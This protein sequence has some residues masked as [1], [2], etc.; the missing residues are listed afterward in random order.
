VRDKDPHVDNLVTLFMGTV[1][2]LDETL[3][4]VPILVFRGSLF[5]VLEE[6]VARDVDPLRPIQ[7]WR[8]D[9]W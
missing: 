7:R 8:N 9:R 3:R 5:R 4:R 1:D 2:E 6:P